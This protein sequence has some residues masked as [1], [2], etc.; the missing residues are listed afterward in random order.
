MGKGS[1]IMPQIGVTSK[2][3]APKAMEVFRPSALST[4]YFGWPGKGVRHQKP[5][6][7]FGR[8]ALLVSDPFSRPCPLFPDPVKTHFSVLTEH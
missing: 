5:E 2:G 1:P 6:R 3:I 7:P 4:L 8:F